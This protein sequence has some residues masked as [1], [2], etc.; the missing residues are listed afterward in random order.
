[1]TQEAFKYLFDKHFD[2]VRNYLYYRCGDA[3]LATDIAQDTFM[4]VWEKQLDVLPDKSVGLFYKI[5]NDLFISRH[6]KIN[7]DAKFKNSLTIDSDEETPESK[8]TYVELSETY[9]R[10]LADM[11]EKQRVVF[12][13]SRSEDLRY[14]EIAERLQLSV[15]AVEK[16]MSQALA[17]FREK[18]AVN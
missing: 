4:R 1:M 10:A 9:E 3:E 14:S 11:N 6:R 8:M 5:A 17:Y 12:L 16:R 13:M 18:L 2:A 7:V 15:K